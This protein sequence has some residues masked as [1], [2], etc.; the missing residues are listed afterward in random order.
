MNLLTANLSTEKSLYKKV[1][2]KNLS[3]ESYQLKTNKKNKKIANCK[4]KN[5]ELYSVNS[6]LST[7]N[8]SYYSG[9]YRTLQPITLMHT[10][11]RPC[12]WIHSS[13]NKHLCCS[14]IE[15]GVT[16]LQY[17]ICISIRT[18]WCFPPFKKCWVDNVN[19][20]TLYMIAVTKC[21]L[22]CSMHN[23]CVPFARFI[24]WTGRAVVSYWDFCMLSSVQVERLGKYAAEGMKLLF[25]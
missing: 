24:K 1:S 12:N 15:T 13:D 9:L 4:V 14:D 25:L 7:V 11:R 18:V 16:A 20:L 22:H 21:T 2:S 6:K 17:P 8:S 23:A 5:C 3:T 19:G 10:G